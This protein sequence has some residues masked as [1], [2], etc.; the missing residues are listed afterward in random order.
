M[1][2]SAWRTLVQACVGYLYHC[3]LCVLLAKSLTHINI[4]V[5][6][7]VSWR[8]HPLW[9]PGTNLRG[10]AGRVQFRHSGCTPVT[11]KFAATDTIGALFVSYSS[12]GR[13][14]SRLFKRQQFCDFLI[15]GYMGALLC[16]I[17]SYNFHP[18][19]TN[20]IE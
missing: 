2:A 11:A 14:M 20:S 19:R 7:S 13:C 15:G 9:T 12:E 4:V 1:T 5:C 10:V 8:M 18:A 16:S 3:V 17:R 6:R